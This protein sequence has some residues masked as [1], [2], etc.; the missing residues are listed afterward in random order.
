MANFYLTRFFIQ[1]NYKSYSMFFF[2]INMF[3]AY[4]K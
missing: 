2:S 3:K 4:I 1:N